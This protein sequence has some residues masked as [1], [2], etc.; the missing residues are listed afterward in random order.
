MMTVIF[1]YPV[2]GIQ[3]LPRPDL[4]SAR[5][6]L[7]E[8]ILARKALQHRLHQVRMAKTLAPDG[9]PE[10]Q[11]AVPKSETYLDRTIQILSDGRRV[12]QPAPQLDR[13]AKHS[14]I[15]GSGR[16][17]RG[18][19]DERGACLVF[20]CHCQ[21]DRAACVQCQQTSWRCLSWNLGHPDSPEDV[22]PFELCV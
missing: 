7:R 11:P 19:R 5:R 1:Y 21:L 12:K 15:A 22:R 4:G 9:M 17:T 18:D 3:W 13:L 6:T 16:F 2:N 10:F 8:T 20:L 14:F